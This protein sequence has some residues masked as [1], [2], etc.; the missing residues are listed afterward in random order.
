MEEIRILVSYE[1]KIKLL[2]NAE[3]LRMLIQ[4]YIRLIINRELSKK[5]GNR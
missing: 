5:D 1:E 3:E 4:Q 2:Q